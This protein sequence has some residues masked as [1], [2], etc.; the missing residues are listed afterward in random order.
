MYARSTT[1]QAQPSSIDAGIAHVRDTVLPALE[2]TDGCLGLSL[3]VDRTS[4][5]CIA[6]SSWESE[7]AMRASEESIRPIRDRAAE[8]FGGSA[9]VEEW[10]IAGM[11]RDH[12]RVRAPVSEQ[13]GSTSIRIR[14]TEASISTRRLSCP[15][16]RSWRDS[17]VPA[18]CRPKVRSWRG[19]GDLRQRRSDGAEQGPVRQDQSHGQPGSKRRGTRP[20]RLRIG[21]RTPAGARDGLTAPF[22]RGG[23]APWSKPSTRPP[24]IRSAQTVMR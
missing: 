1:I 13:H 2:G 24:P 22:R 5:R 6:T 9:Q 21:S 10:E 19:R 15:P 8:L 16:W 18:C 4:G 7:E 11:H 23:A 17:A 3:L 12:R 20:V 14:S